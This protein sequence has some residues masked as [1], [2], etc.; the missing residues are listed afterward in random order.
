VEPAL[1]RLRTLLAHSL[2]GRQRGGRPGQRPQ[3][4]V[5]ALDELQALAGH[6]QVG[7]WVGGP[8]V[9]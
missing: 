6:L 3:A 4:V 8:G 5:A 2:A 9:P 1:F 7:G